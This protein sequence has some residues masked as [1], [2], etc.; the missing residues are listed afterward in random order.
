MDDIPIRHNGAASG[1]GIVRA[2][3]RYGRLGETCVDRSGNIGVGKEID[4]QIQRVGADGH[5]VRGGH[6]NGDHLR[7][8]HSTGERK[9]IRPIPLRIEHN[10]ICVYRDRSRLAIHI[11]EIGHTKGNIYAGVVWNRQIVHSCLSIKRNGNTRIIGKRQIFQCVSIIRIKERRARC[12]CKIGGASKSS[13]H[14]ICPGKHPTQICTGRDRPFSNVLVKGRRIR[15]HTAKL[16]DI[17]DIPIRYVLIKICRLLERPK[18]TCNIAGVPFRDVAVEGRSA[19][20]NRV[21]LGDVGHVPI[22][23]RRKSRTR[24]PVWTNSA[25]RIL[26]Q[27]VNNK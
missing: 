15:K 9:R 25:D 21:H 13:M 16:S 12:I 7:Y 1:G 26:C 4:R 19:R 3:P 27:T 17:G 20:E 2:I 22:R 18:H 5:T 23:H 14:R 11:R 6:F 8:S 10:R 24:R